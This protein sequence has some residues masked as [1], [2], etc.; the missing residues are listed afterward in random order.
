MNS[1]NKSQT[2]SISSSYPYT[3]LPTPDILPQ[4]TQRSITINNASTYP[5]VDNTL[6][7]TSEYYRQ[8]NTLIND[9]GVNVYENSSQKNSSARKSFNMDLNSKKQTILKSIEKPLR[10]K[11]I[12]SREASSTPTPVSTKKASN[13]NQNIAYLQAVKRIALALRAKMQPAKVTR[14]YHKVS[15]K[16]LVYKIVRGLKESMLRN[17]AQLQQQ[18]KRSLLDYAIRVEQGQH[19][20]YYKVN[21]V[22]KSKM[23]SNERCREFEHSNVV[24]TTNSNSRKVSKEKTGPESRPQKIVLGTKHKTDK[25]ENNVIP[26]EIQV[27]SYYTGNKENYILSSQKPSKNTQFINSTAIPLDKQALL[28]TD[29]NVENTSKQSR[30]TD[31]MNLPQSKKKEY[32]MKAEETEAKIEQE[33]EHLGEMMVGE[34]NKKEGEL[35]QDPEATDSKKYKQQ[36]ID[37]FRPNVPLTYEDT[38]EMK[39][40]TEKLKS[41]SKNNRSKQRIKDRSKRTILDINKINCEDI[42]FKSDFESYLSSHNIT[43]VNDSPIPKMNDAQEM[44]KFEFWSLYFKYLLFK[45]KK[46]AKGNGNNSVFGSFYLVFKQSL[47]NLK[48]STLSVDLVIDFFLNDIIGP[49]FTFKEVQSYLDSRRYNCIYDLVDE[50]YYEVYNG[51]KRR[52]RRAV[53]NSGNYYVCPH[54]LEQKGVKVCELNSV[55]ESVNPTKEVN[56]AEVKENNKETTEENNA[57]NTS[58]GAE[59]DE[60]KQKPKNKTNDSN[61]EHVEFDEELPKKKKYSKR[62]KTKSKRKYY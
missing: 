42:N 19:A 41:I 43:I 8:T 47:R 10:A 54:D 22:N 23:E 30:I 15:Y 35:N 37:E 48:S 61:S 45:Y 46:G 36:R 27:E 55:F 51:Q 18:Q 58:F 14:F 59:N 17:K 39:A 5:N 49:N 38:Q 40:F 56:Q 4:Y 29:N 24:N 26:E 2:I 62:K 52:Q 34:D 57:F 1:K 11:I 50:A 13:L 9:S 60:N 12:M 25:I 32:D 53:K 6:S 21:K 44:E 20:V 28:N 31:Y 16:A 33:K 3:P 7:S